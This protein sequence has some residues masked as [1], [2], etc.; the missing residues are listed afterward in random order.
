VTAGLD[1]SAQD[2]LRDLAPKALGSLLRRYRDF[3]G[4]EDAVQEALIA[5]TLQWPTQGMPDNRKVGRSRWRRAGSL[6]RSAPARHEG[7]ENS[8]S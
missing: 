8:W 5:A 2:L 3:G 7:C 1:D 4:C 6:T